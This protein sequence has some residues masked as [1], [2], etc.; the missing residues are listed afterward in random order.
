MTEKDPADR[1]TAAHCVELL[2]ALANGQV[3]LAAPARRAWPVR[4]GLTTAG[5]AAAAALVVPAVLGPTSIP[6]RPAGGPTPD[7]GT[8]ALEPAEPAGAAGPAGAADT[9]VDPAESTG[10]AGTGASADA[11]EPASATEPTGTAEP[12]G[13][14]PTARAPVVESPETGTAGSPPAAPDQAAEQASAENGRDNGRGR[15]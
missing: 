3:P 10:P 15:N 2:D 6:G 5:L 12:S 13:T 11:T 4:I 1:P 9:A 7:P 8:G 14:A